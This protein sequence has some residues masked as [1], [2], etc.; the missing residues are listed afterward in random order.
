MDFVAKAQG[1]RLL[2]SSPVT[3]LRY[4]LWDIDINRLYGTFA[5]EAEALEFA[6]VLIH[7]HGD[8]YADHLALGREHEDGSITVPLAS[9]A[10]ISRSA[11]NRGNA[12]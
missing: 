10:L 5:T 7:K 4:R 11:A 3:D 2:P 8:A 9:A 6:R 12:D 1:W